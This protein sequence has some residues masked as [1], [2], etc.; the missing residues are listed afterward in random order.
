MP[1]LLYIMI[2][3]FLG[4]RLRSYAVPFT[5]TESISYRKTGK[6]LYTENLLHAPFDCLVGL[7][8]LTTA[9]YLNLLLRSA[10]YARNVFPWGRS[11]LKS[12]LPGLSGNLA[13]RILVM[14]MLLAKLFSLIF[15]CISVVK[16]KDDDLKPLFYLTLAKVLTV[17]LALFLAD[18]G[19]FFLPLILALIMFARFLWYTLFHEIIRLS[20]FTGKFRV[21]ENFYMLGMMALAALWAAFLVWPTFF[22]RD[23]VVY[24]GAT[25]FSDLSPHTALTRSFGVGANIPAQYPHFGYAGMRYHFFFYFL[26]GMLNLMGLP[27]DWALNLPSM[28]GTIGFMQAL[29]FAAWLLSGKLS[30]WPLTILLFAFR[31]SFS[32][33]W[34]MQQKMQEGLTFFQA[35]G[36]LQAAKQYAGPLLHD[37]WGLYNLNVYANQRHLLWGLAL[38]FYFILLCLR[39]LPEDAH[40]KSFIK[41]ETW[42]RGPEPI[43]LPYIFLFCFPL[44]FWHGSATICMLLILAFFALFA[45]KKI[46]YVYLAAVTAAGALFFLFLLRDGYGGGQALGSSLF[47]WGYIL[48]DRSAGGVLLFLLTLYGPAFIF[49]LAA[50]FVFPKRS[51]K[52]AAL[53][54]FLP[55]LFGL[56]ISLTPDVTV[57]HKYFMMTGLFFIPFI[58]AMLSKLAEAGKYAPWRRLAAAGLILLL[59]FTGVT[60]FWA[61]KNQSTWRITAKTRDSFTDWIYEHTDPDVVNITPPWAFHAYFLCGRQS[62]YGHSYYAASAG[63]PVGERLEEIKNFL[64]A[65]AGHEEALRAYAKEHKLAYLLIDNGWRQRDDYYINEKALAEIFPQAAAFPEYDGLIIYDLGDRDEAALP[66]AGGGIAARPEG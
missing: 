28:F 31:S 59:T 55:M 51:Q 5:L 7:T 46:A 8:I 27:L 4:K 33:F 32:G 11:L 14:G 19:F 1:A 39:T 29:G 24:A 10:L 63:Y 62:Y 34:L 66:A 3:Y 13:L 58:A 12:F 6:M 50:P 15:R 65:P 17:L 22:M 37:D 26:S 44:A 20:N 21:K 25:V 38:A 48:E 16:M 54:F 2:A 40:I 43:W 56:T 45:E 41:K 52:I 9:L 18:V 53:S 47:H 57:N 36:E 61:Y 35:L 64:A 49:M 60:D 42:L 23:S 30:A